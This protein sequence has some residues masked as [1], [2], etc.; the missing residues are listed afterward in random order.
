MKPEFKISPNNEPNFIK[1]AV[2]RA[3]VLPG[4]GSYSTSA[5]NATLGLAKGWK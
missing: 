4:P 5:R 1:A 3:K 2:K